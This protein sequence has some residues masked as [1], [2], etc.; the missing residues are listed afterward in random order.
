MPGCQTEY[1]QRSSYARPK[2]QFQQPTVVTYVCFLSECNK[3]SQDRIY[4]GKKTA[5]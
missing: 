2:S 1:S 4:E 3:L 5:K